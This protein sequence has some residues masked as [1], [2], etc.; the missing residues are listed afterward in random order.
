[1]RT[2]PSD[3]P[4]KRDATTWLT[5]LMLG[6][7][8]FTPNILGPLMPFLRA[9]LHLS[10][11]QGGLVLSALACGMILS[12]LS[13]ERIAG[14]WGRRRVF[15][16]GGAGSAVGAL[17][18]AWGN[19]PAMALIAALTMGFCGCLAV[20][21]IQAI[22]S[23]RHAE[24]RAI[25]LTESNVAAA[26]GS[27]LAPI[28]VGGLQRSGAGWRG[29]LYLAAAAFAL[30]ATSL[31]QVPIPDDP[32]P[33]GR[34]VTEGR[35][36]AAG[37]SKLPVQFWA[38]WVVIL[39]SVAIEWCLIVWGADFLETVIGLSRVN[40][41]TAMSAFLLAML[42]GRL[43]VSR[44]TRVMA[45]TTILLIAFGDGWVGF[46]MFWLAR[47]PILNLTGLFIA[48]LG[49]ANL[50]PLAMSIAV[51]TAPRQSNL[52]SARVFL[53]TGIAI[54]CAPLFLGWI[55]DRVSIQNAYGIV[56]GFLVTAPA[57][58]IISHH[59]LASGVR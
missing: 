52:A 35:S 26:A 57:V 38:Y 50:F 39:M 56:M 25:A 17:C 34:S 53:A 29:A 2:A 45:P 54:L 16:G 18:L 8:S 32:L 37:R 4:F 49:V 58:T 22:L 31:Y 3:H 41:S 10:Y 19:Q 15:W 40:A 11:T 30:I 55:A 5:Y 44:L 9:E 24:L 48:G 20:V 27:A 33:P 21:M 51:G 28:A 42:L 23:D 13:A 7:L 36:G 43:A 59:A 12:G 1:M 6:Y 46:M 47:S 14:R